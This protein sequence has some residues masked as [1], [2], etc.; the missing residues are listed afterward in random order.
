MKAIV[1]DTYGPPDV[2]RLEDVPTP[3]PTDDEVL[4]KV[5]AVSINGSDTE[6]L[7]GSPAYARI[8]GILRPTKRILGSDIAGCVE[9]VGKNHR[10]FRAGDEVFGELPGYR[11]GFAEYV[12]THGR[13]L[14]VKPGGLTFEQAA[15]IPQG[16][17][18]AWQGIRGRGQV[19]Q[20]QSVLING[21][22]GSAGSF[23]VQLAKLC[24]AEVTGVD[25]G[26][27]LDFIRSLG[28]D[29]VLDYTREDF[30]KNHGRYD[31]ILD[32]I[33][34]RPALAY[35]RALKQGGSYFLIGGSVATMLQVL[36][37]GP[38][39]RLLKKRD[40]KVIGIPQNREDLLSIAEY[41]ATGRVVVPI[42]KRYPLHRVP[43]AMRYVM[44]GRANGK[45]VITITDGR[46]N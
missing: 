13:T 29:H 20:G 24:G 14:A 31:R 10:Q 28:A 1:Y 12:T 15:A 17:V 6:G 7:L 40:L 30:T 25:R 3:I 27:K 41:C 32:L 34:H 39:V 23:A 4:I 36:L 11:G 5:H 37:A 9:A 26:N 38:L 44:E 21:A 22:G 35:P 2:L 16:G 46:E 33:A 19:Q 42:D 45:V 43:E 18:I 8:G